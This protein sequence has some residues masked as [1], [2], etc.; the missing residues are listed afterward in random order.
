MLRTIL[1][2]TCLI[3][4]LG[5]AACT[6]VSDAIPVVKIEKK[7]SKRMVVP[8]SYGRTEI[9][10]EEAAQVCETD[11][12]R[13][14]VLDKDYDNDLAKALVLEKGKKAPTVVGEVTVNC[15]DYFLKKSIEPDMR[16]MQTVSSP[17]TIPSSY[18]QTQTPNYSQPN[19]QVI[20][21]TP[22]QISA[23]VIQ[24]NT[25]TEPQ[26]SYYRVKRGDS[27]YNIARKYCTSVKAISRTN[28]LRDA[29]H[30]DVGQVLRLPDNA[31]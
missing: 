15:R 20:V 3:M 23:P 18:E 16:V 31:C 13:A 17:N 9:N 4:P 27:V 8:A 29:T 6:S 11:I 7:K 19:Q 22:A 5:V 26:P 1:L 24:A 21:D 14:R 2:S 10:T 30:I 12:M 25:P 28:G